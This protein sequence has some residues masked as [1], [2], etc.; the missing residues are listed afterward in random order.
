MRL[1][2]RCTTNPVEL[3]QKKLV[4]C[5]ISTTNSPLAS[6]KELIAD[7]RTLG[8][9]KRERKKEKKK[10]KGNADACRLYS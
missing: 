8:P 9:V 4:V 2:G 6:P 5:S 3:K 1:A 10:K 7:T